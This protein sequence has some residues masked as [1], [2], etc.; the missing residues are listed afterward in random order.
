MPQLGANAPAAG[1]KLARLMLYGREKTRKTMWALTAAQAGF[2]VLLIDGDDGGHIASQFKSGMEKVALLNVHDSASEFHFVKFVTHLVTGNGFA[3]NETKRVLASK[4]D[5]NPGWFIFPGGTKTLTPN[6]VLIIDSWTALTASMRLQYSRQNNINLADAEKTD[7]PGYGWMQ[8]LTTHILNCI[9]G[10]PCHVIV[11]AHEQQYDKYEGIGQDRKIAWS[12]TQPL[13]ASG[14]TGSQ[15]GKH[16]SDIIRF[17]G[18]S[19]ARSSLEI[20]GTQHQVGGSRFLKPQKVSFE[21]PDK[22]FGGDQNWSFGDYCK[23]AGF[24]ADQAY[25]PGY[26]FK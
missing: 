16:F 1:N 13:A 18:S 19:A 14:N 15:L 9:H 25:K 3:F 10:F 12:R 8:N 21:G 23:A 24:V 4:D 5:G 17:V 2:N 7:W 20:Y 6:D 26:S 11:I 22:P